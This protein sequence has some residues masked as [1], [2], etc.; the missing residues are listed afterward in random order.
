[1]DMG[2]EH[3]NGANRI[4]CP[5]DECPHTVLDKYETYE[6]YMA[7]EDSK[8][9]VHEFFQTVASCYEL[10]NSNASASEFFKG[11]CSRLHF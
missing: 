2:K 8:I 11:A 10:A 9:L 3:Y 6:Q 1:M 4:A 7:S 5:Y